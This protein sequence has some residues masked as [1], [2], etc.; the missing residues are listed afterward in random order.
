MRIHS[1]DIGMKNDTLNFKSVLLRCIKQELNTMPYISYA[2]IE[3]FK[4]NKQTS[5]PAKEYMHWCFLY[6]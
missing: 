5:K 1:I 6:F 4:L 3:K 2:I